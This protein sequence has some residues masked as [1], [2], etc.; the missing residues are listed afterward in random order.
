MN[1]HINESYLQLEGALESASDGLL[2]DPIPAEIYCHS[3]ADPSIL[4]PELRASG[5]QTLTV[6]ALHAPHHLFADD[7]ERMRGVALE[8]VLRSLNSVLAEPVEG[9]LLLDANGAPCIEVNTT[10]D[11]EQA[12][13]IPTGNIFHTPLDWP[14]AESESEVGTWGVETSI[15]NVTLCGAGARRGGGVSG[16]PGHNAA[17]YVLNRKQ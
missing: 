2:A 6:F 7:N 1:F 3:L 14:F 12:L 4:G 5:A 17:A 16:I 10:V 8:A 15:P 13:G 11:I 9:C